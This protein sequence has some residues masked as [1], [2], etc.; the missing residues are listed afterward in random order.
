MKYECRWY[1][2]LA[3]HLPHTEENRSTKQGDEGFWN[4]SGIEGIYFAQRPIGT[5][6]HTWEL[7]SN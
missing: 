4:I 6:N 7:C 2:E 3:K 1:W 5:G